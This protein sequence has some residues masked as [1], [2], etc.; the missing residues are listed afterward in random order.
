MRMPSMLG[1]K[2]DTLTT[3]RELRR[4]LK[5]EVGV[6]IVISLRHVANPGTAKLVNG[7]HRIKFYASGYH[8]NVS[9]ALN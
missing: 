9:S 7:D 4:T 3:R 6:L 2:Q 8:H 5:L 1:T